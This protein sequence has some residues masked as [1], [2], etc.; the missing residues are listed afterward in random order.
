MFVIGSLLHTKCN[1]LLIPKIAVNDPYSGRNERKGQFLDPSELNEHSLRVVDP[2]QNVL[3]ITI[4]MWAPFSFCFK[5]ITLIVFY[6]FRSQKLNK[7][8]IFYVCLNINLARRD[9][10]TTTKTWHGLEHNIT[11]ILVCFQISSSDSFG[12]KTLTKVSL[13]INC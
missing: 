1:V 2:S 12:D 3:G 11:V 8:Y 4:L 9:W 7:M 6:F 13:L 10:S 5:L